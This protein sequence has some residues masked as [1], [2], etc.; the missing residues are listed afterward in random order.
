MRT[1]DRRLTVYTASIL[2][3]AVD[4]RRHLGTERID[5]MQQ[6]PGTV[7]PVRLT[8]YEVLIEQV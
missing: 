4:W 1:R 3:D 2:A 7:E 8:T 6:I 5:H